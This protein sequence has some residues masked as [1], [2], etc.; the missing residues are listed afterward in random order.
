MPERQGRSLAR[1]CQV[2]LDALAGVA[3]KTGARIRVATARAW[4]NAGAP[5]RVA[6]G[7]EPPDDGVTARP[8]A[9]V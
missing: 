7:A 1:R 5:N 6:E 4:L 8:I 9:R 3:G 2:Q